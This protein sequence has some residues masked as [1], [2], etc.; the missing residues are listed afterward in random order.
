MWWIVAFYAFSLL[1]IGFI[2]WFYWITN[3]PTY[4]DGDGDVSTEVGYSEDSMGRRVINP[5]PSTT[6]E[7]DQVPHT[8]GAGGI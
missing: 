8:G 2:I 4:R 1:C 3:F 7:G 5:E 6:Q